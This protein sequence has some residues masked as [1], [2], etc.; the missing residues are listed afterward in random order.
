METPPQI[1]LLGMFLL[2]LVSMALCVLFMK[3]CEE[4]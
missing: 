1:W 2:G 3:A 4:I